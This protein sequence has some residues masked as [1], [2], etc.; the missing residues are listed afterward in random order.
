M[1]L[2]SI[3]RSLAVQSLL[4]GVTFAAGYVTN[5]DNISGGASLS[6]ADGWVTNDPY[7]EA[8]DAGQADYV[9]VV[10]N[11]SATTSDHLALLGGATGFAPGQ[12]TVY[13]WRP[14]DLSGSSF[15]SFSVGMA[16]TSSASPR[17]NED[18]FGWTFRDST[19][20]TL[21]SLRFDPST[22]AT[23]DLNIR[24][25][26]SSNTELTVGPT[27]DM[28]YNSI[29]SLDVSVNAL[30]EVTVNFTDASSA[31]FEVIAGAATGID[32]ADI[33]GVAATWSL[34]SS[35]GENAAQNDFG[36]NSLVFDNYSLV[37]EPSSALLAC[38]AGLGFVTR[39]KRA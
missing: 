25:F 31:T 35:S 21:F 6:D 13:L 1:S 2:Q 8:I 29:Y 38:L 20:A 30:G 17:T 12:P 16:V 10:P 4:V 34:A 7:V 27:W 36:S 26:D 19:N 9:G 37:P 14:V 32:P 15:A 33:A 28:Y 11:Y 3:S 5:F 24:M 39:R 23:G 18:T 22:A